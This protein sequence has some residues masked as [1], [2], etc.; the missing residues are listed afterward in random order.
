MPNRGSERITVWSVNAVYAQL[1][2]VPDI[3]PFVVKKEH[4]MET[5]PRPFMDPSEVRLLASRVNFLR[6]LAWTRNRTTTHGSQAFKL[7]QP[8]VQK[9]FRREPC[10]DSSTPPH[11]FYPATSVYCAI[12]SEKL[13][14]V[15]LSQIEESHARRCLKKLE[16]S[17][18][19]AWMLRP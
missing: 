2:N 19:P 12:G 14:Y 18:R 13:P 11:K 4:V 15:V 3:P 10:E 8:R 9:G 16:T 6:P 5:D 17:R 7:G 1:C